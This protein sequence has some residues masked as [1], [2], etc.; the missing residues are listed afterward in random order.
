MNTHKL[1]PFF[2]NFFNGS[3]GVWRLILSLRK[4]QS[5]NNDYSNR[6]RYFSFTDV[7]YIF[8]DGIFNLPSLII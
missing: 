3:L 6:R 7:V 4:L 5:I 8:N 1:C 2:P